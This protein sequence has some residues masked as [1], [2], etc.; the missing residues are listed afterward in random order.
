MYS[1][2]EVHNYVRAYLGKIYINTEYLS[3][4]GTKLS[5]CS[6]NHW[7][8]TIISKNLITP[9]QGQYYLHSWINVYFLFKKCVLTTLKSV[10]KN[11]FNNNATTSHMLNSPIARY[12]NLRFQNKHFSFCV[13]LWL[14]EM[15]ARCFLPVKKKKIFESVNFNEGWNWSISTFHV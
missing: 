8:N 6:C 15:C 10:C 4:K 5:W 14:A 7:G 13:E 2:V 11:E 12:F 3:V 1:R 9:I